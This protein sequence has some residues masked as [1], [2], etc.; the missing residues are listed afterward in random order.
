[1]SW[2]IRQNKKS[3]NMKKKFKKII[4]S[5]ALLVIVLMF[6]NA[7]KKDDSSSTPTVKLGQSYQGG[8]VFYILK[9]GDVGYNASVQHGL[10]APENDQASLYGIVWAPSSINILVGTTSTAIGTGNANTN[11]IVAKLG[12]GNYAAKLCSD[13]VLNGYSDWYLPSKDE[14][15]KILSSPNLSYFSTGNHYWSSSEVNQ[16]DVW[17]QT[18]VSGQ[19]SDRSKTS[20]SNVRAIRSF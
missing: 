2:G 1:M 11:A 6:S 13:L 17:V 5:A 20:A 14:L 18:Y 16:S 8:I 7:C 15:N 9:A 19:Q 4:Q 12:S 3:N 10:I